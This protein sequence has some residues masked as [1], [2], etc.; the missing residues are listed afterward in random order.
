MEMQTQTVSYIIKPFSD[1]LMPANLIARISLIKS[2]NNN[3]LLVPKEAVLGNETQTDFWVM[4]LINDT[5][6]VRVNIKKGYENNDEIEITEPGFLKSDRIVLKGN[7][8]L[9]DT[10]GVTIIR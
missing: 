2:S 3:A 5:T 1:N 9:A 4:K 10:A 8:G 6:A 7:Y